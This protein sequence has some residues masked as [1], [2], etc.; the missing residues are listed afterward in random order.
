MSLST[1]IYTAFKEMELHLH[2]S[3]WRGKENDCVNLFAHR[4]L[5]KA[6]WPK[7]E[8]VLRSLYLS[9]AG[10]GENRQYEKIW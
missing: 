7:I 6:V 4:F 1:K 2:K 9:S 8:L 3:K 10:R 5:A